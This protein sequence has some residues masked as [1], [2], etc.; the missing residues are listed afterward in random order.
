MNE[1][2]EL[3]RAVE[4]V[5]GLEEYEIFSKRIGDAI[6]LVTSFAYSAIQERKRDKYLLKQTQ[7][8]ARLEEKRL[9]Q[10]GIQSPEEQRK[11]LVLE[12]LIADSLIPVENKENK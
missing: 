1:F 4:T 12:R 10:D 9:G 5:K 2:E 11:S 7:E 3:E 6:L 8:Q